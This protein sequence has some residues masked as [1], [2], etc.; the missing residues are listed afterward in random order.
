M[1]FFYNRF[2][3]HTLY[4]SASSGRTIKILEFIYLFIKRNHCPPSHLEIKEFFGIKSKISSNF[5]ITKLVKEG[6]IIKTKKKGS[7]R[8]LKI[9]EKGYKHLGIDPSMKKRIIQLPVVDHKGQ[10]SNLN[11][12]ECKLSFDLYFFASKLVKE[13]NELKNLF[14]YNVSGEIKNIDDVKRGDILIVNAQT[15]AKENDIVLVSDEDYFK[16]EK[17]SNKNS[18]GIVGVVKAIF[19]IT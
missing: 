1:Y 3:R 4:A 15:D 6:L 13:F 12:I 2:R 14:I 19:K 5:Y 11:D 18:G 16:V 7:H 10:L 17:F 9:T 8:C